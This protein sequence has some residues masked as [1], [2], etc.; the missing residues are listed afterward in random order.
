MKTSPLAAVLAFVVA[1]VLGTSFAAPALAHTTLKSSDPKKGSTVEGVESVTLTYTESVRF[2]VV[3]V[4]DAGGQA[5][6]DGKPEVDGPVVTQ[7]VSGDLP[8]GEYTIA[9]R[10]VSADG[11]PI[12]GEIPFTVK[13]PEAAAPS[14]S[15][16]PSAAAPSPAETAVAAP[17]SVAATPASRREEQSGGIPVWVWIVVFGIAGIGIGMALSMRKKT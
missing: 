15:P 11:H 14:P 5:Y 8:S 2:P 9:W 16:S 13:A 7:K 6:H 17:S 12:E 3:L 4:R 10:V 1:A